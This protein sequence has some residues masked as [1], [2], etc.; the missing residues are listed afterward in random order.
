MNLMIIIA[1]TISSSI[2][3]LGV[4]ISYGLR[5]VHIDVI[6]NLLIAVICFCMSVSGITFGRWIATILPGVVPVVVG[7]FLLLIIG[8]RIMLLSRPARKKAPRIKET[9]H[10]NRKN[11]SSLK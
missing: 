9:N 11:S 6:K 4:G 10:A 5:K 8:I 7:A 1:L 3:N 2:D